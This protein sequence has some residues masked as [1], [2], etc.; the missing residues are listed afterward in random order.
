M[1]EVKDELTRDNIL[2]RISEYDIFRMY[3]P[4][5][6][7]IDKKFNAELN[8]AKK[9]SFPS[10]VI[11][12]YK[13]RLWYKDFGST[14]KSMDCFTYIQKKY[15]MSYIQ[16]LGI[17]NL[18]FNLGLN[19]VQLHRPSLN[20]VG[21]P[22]RLPP[23]IRSEFTI[24]EP[25]SRRWLVKDRKFWESYGITKPTLEHYNVAPINWYLLRGKFYNTDALAY[26]YYITTEDS[27]KYYKIYQPESKSCKWITNCK[28]RHY[29]G[30]DQ[31]PFSGDLLIITKSL[32]DVMLLYQFGYSS[33]APGTESNLVESDFMESLKKRFS[34]IIIFF[35]NDVAGKAGAKKNVYHY[36]IKS[37][38]IPEESG[39]KD[40]SDFVK[41][42]SYE[43]GRLLINKL[44]N[45]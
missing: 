20:Y 3:C 4:N 21:L 39:V 29:Q 42:Y 16:A 8:R 34:E 24:I 6:K 11:T 14:E 28:A 33:I 43:E 44:L 1:F 26:C 22:D 37:I 17:V 41:R 32:K 12:Y 13:G 36:G 45:E 27:V 38:I 10:A 9:E 30:Y 2:N 25:N 35:D 23:T 18:D 7:E 31:L 15:G 40:I 5:F 19:P